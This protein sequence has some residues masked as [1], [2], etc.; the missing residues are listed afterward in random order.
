MWNL[1]KQKTKN[2]NILRDNRELIDATEEV[3]REMGEKGE[4]EYE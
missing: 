3:G 4:R 1:K 2:R